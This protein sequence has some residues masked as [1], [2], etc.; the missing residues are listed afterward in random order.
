MLKHVCHELAEQVIF[1]DGLI[2]FRRHAHGTLEPEQLLGTLQEALEARP[3]L[4]HAWSAIIQ[5]LLGMNRAADAWRYA[6]EAAERFPLLPVLWL[7]K[8]EV[9]RVRED[10]KGE[11]EALVNAYQINPFW[12]KTIHCLSDYHIRQGE[13]AEA[14]RLLEQAV[15]QSPFDALLH[16]LLAETLWS[17]GEKSSAFEQMQKAAELDPGYDRVWY[18]LTVWGPEINDRGRV[19]ELAKKLTR[20]HPQ[21][22][23]SWLILAK[24]ICE[25]P[26]IQECL[27]ALDQALAW[28]PLSCE[29]HD[30]RA[31]VL[32]KA[33]R[34]DEAQAA[35]SPAIYQGNIPCQLR[36]RVAWIFAEQGKF[37][38]AINLMR[39]VVREEPWFYEGYMRIADWSKA[40]NDH[41]ACLDAAENLIRINPLSEISYGYLG[42]AYMLKVN[43]REAKIALLRAL[44][45][46]P[47]YNFARLAMFDIEMADGNI[48]MASQHLEHLR[49]AD[50]SNPYV[51]AREVQ[52]AVKK[53]KFPAAFEALR[54]VCTLPCDSNWPIQAAVESLIKAGKTTKVFKILDDVIFQPEANPLVSEFWAQT[55][56]KTR[57][58]SR[59]NRIKDMKGALRTEAFRNYARQIVHQRRKYRFL[60]FL[61]RHAGWIHNNTELWGI[62]GYAL[63]NLYMPDRVLRWMD[64]WESRT[65]VEAWMLTHYNDALRDKKRAEEA[66]RA[67][68]K[69]LDLPRETC[70]NWLRV[71]LAYDEEIA[72]NQDQMRNWL[73]K[74]SAEDFA[75]DNSKY[76]YTLLEHI[77]KNTLRAPRNAAQN[78]PGR[79]NANRQGISGHVSPQ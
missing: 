28:D 78:I 38:D 46:N 43:D 18:C 15:A 61:R 21:E 58:F 56:F 3:D 20:T 8:A 59:A 49:T 76:I 17:L 64:D 13:N 25:D 16:G 4:W 54:R 52:F 47:S 53:R 2:A 6:Q 5:Q 11:Y 35:C 69:A 1:G 65:G 71:W 66:H 63:N 41:D 37:Q 42:D 36:G 40:I 22:A 10:Y 77:G 44:E 34:W 50:A 19:A 33:K 12:N 45:I 26:N 29:A 62:T 74:I 72:G 30:M 24:I 79:E 55:L 75:T 7:D 51:A 31:Y 39:D 9:C 68:V 60:L 73:Q 32:A 67:C 14:R 23:R 57:K 70:K 48:G 27:E